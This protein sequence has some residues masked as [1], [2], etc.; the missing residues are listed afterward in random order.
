MKLSMVWYIFFY[1]KTNLEATVQ[2]LLQT[3]DNGLISSLQDHICSSDENKKDF[4]KV[5]QKNIDYQFF[6]QY[7]H[8]IL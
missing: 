2:M 1:S 3:A 8:L 4:F 5:L 6:Q 7:F